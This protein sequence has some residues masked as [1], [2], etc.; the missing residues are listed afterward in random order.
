LASTTLACG[1]SEKLVRLTLELFL[2]MTLIL[3]LTPAVLFHQVQAAFP[4]GNG[5]IAFTRQGQIYVMNADGSGQ[6]QLTS[7]GSNGEP[8]W[9]SDGRK[10]VFVSSRDQGGVSGIYVMNADGSALAQL[11][12]GAYPQYMYMFPSWSPDSSKILFLGLEPGVVGG[13]Y[14]AIFVMNADGS[15]QTQLT[16]SS[17]WHMSPAWSPDGSRVA[18][19]SYGSL[20]TH[21]QIFVMN[22]DGSGTTNISYDPQAYDSD[23][24]WSP[25]GSKIAFVRE[26]SA[27]TSIWIMNAD[28]SG[29]TQLTS[30][31][32][33]S[34]RRYLDSSPAWSPDGKK[35][36]FDSNGW[37]ND[38]TYNIYVM[39]ADGTSIVRLTDDGG[40]EPDWQ[41]VGRTVQL[42]SYA[43]T[44]T[45]LPLGTAIQYY[46]DGV[47]N[48]TITT[49]ET[50]TLG[51]TLGR[52]HTIYAD[53]VA[54][55]GTGARYSCP[56]NVWFT[57]GASLHTFIYKKQYNLRISYDPMGVFSPS[58]LWFD[59][60]S[61]AEF[62]A[63][64]GTNGT[65]ARQVF[66]QWSGDY[67]GASVNG[68][69][70]M[71]GPK[72]VT[73]KYKAQ[74]RLRVTFDPPEIAQNVTVSNS[75]WYDAGQTAALGPVPQ[76]IPESSARRFAWVSWNVDNMTQPGTSVQVIMDRPH[77]VCL[78]YQTEYHLLVTSPLGE[79]TGS[80]WYVS[81]QNASFGVAYSGSDLFAK[82]TLT[83]WSLE[84]SNMM[85][86]LPSTVSE[87]TMDRPY[88]I[89]AQWNTEYTPWVFIL[90][91]VPAMVIFAVGIVVIVKHPAP[92]EVEREVERLRLSLA[93]GL[94]RLKTMTLSRQKSRPP[95][96]RICGHCGFGN[97]PY[98]AAFC[99]KCGSSLESRQ[100]P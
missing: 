49:N 29:Q 57:S 38:T 56:D 32:S 19:V 64:E 55:D 48:G 92:L 1:K 99:V 61:T 62:S 12:A 13:N 63:P 4:G 98:A 30:P 2:M 47:L 43:F 44:V 24:S 67:S 51:L 46:L 54:Y 85:K 40:S 96:A 81:G 28:G 97:P 78:K 18:F 79:P 5:K 53:P 89:E 94:G 83:G 50:R 74:Y 39:N 76:I 35:I 45:G 69:M 20:L 42:Q 7:L 91:L 15:G 71:D 6:T 73:A 33:D 65:D 70:R 90:P 25:D 37:P 9:S 52:E 87:V 27:G 86:T 23:P 8:R 58:T 21:T 77:S 11:K 26:E 14:P 95:P 22:A 84:S 72:S 88:V 31:A 75:A 16:N 34:P 59:A 100:E 17:V 10:I 3:S 80:G 82:H 60:N 41:P 66:V 68:S 93:S 36:L